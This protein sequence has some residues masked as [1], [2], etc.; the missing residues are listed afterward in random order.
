MQFNE[1]IG[2]DRP[3]NKPRAITESQKASKGLTVGGECTGMEREGMD[4]C[5][6]TVNHQ[7][8]RGEGEKISWVL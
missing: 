6:G 2:S 7:S 4:E 1:K 3:P 8:E 5:C